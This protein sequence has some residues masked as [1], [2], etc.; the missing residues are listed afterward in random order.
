MT[1]V[2]SRNHAFETD[3][4]F[5]VGYIYLRFKHKVCYY[6]TFINISIGLKPGL[7]R[8]YICQVPREML[9]TEAYLGPRF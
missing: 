1:V 2:Y 8:I 9:K 5:E 3:I 7:S 6:K 4:A